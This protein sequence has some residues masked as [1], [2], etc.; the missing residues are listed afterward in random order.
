MKKFFVAVFATM[1][2]FAGLITG[3][4]YAEGNIA[5]VDGVEYA[6]FDEAVTAAAGTKTII[7]LADYVG[8][9]QMTPDQTLIVDKT[10]GKFNAP[11][12]T[13]ENIVKST[14]SGK[15]YTYTTAPASVE[16]T[17]ADGTIS[18]SDRIGTVAKGNSYR[19][20]ADLEVG[21]TTFGG[22][23]TKDLGTITFD[24]GGHTLTNTNTDASLGA[25][26]FH[27]KVEKAELIIK[28]GKI[29]VPNEC[30]SVFTVKAGQ[31]ITLESDLEVEAKGDIIA[32]FGEGATV[33]TSAALSTTGT[34]GIVGNGSPEN[35]GTII[36]ITGG[37][38]KS[39]EYA[40]YHPQ[41]G[42]I[43]IT[44]GELEATS[45]AVEIRAGELN[46][47]GGKFTATSESQNIRKNP[48]GPTTT[49]AALA[50][51]QHTTKLPLSV[52]ISGGE[53]IGYN[54][55]YEDNI[56]EN[57]AE[58]IAKVTASITGGSFS[59]TSSTRTPIESYDLARFISGGSYSLDSS[60]YYLVE[61]YVYKET[62]SGYVVERLAEVDGLDALR[63]NLPYDDI[64]FILEPQSEL[65]DD[66]LEALNLSEYKET[67]LTS[68]LFAAYLV[69]IDDGSFSFIRE[70]GDTDITFL[71][72]VPEDIPALADGY[73]RQF[74]I[75]GFHENTEDDSWIVKE[76]PVVFTE[77]DGEQY[78][79]FATREFSSFSLGYNDTK[80]P[81][82][83]DSGKNS[84]FASVIPVKM[85]FQA[86][87]IDKQKSVVKNTTLFYSV[88]AKI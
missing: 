62:E 36:N 65:L 79:S 66:Q 46:I 52:N 19:L 72:K 2:T 80:L 15:V 84:P 33:N 57:P 13:G 45:A 86:C 8:T 71:M 77:I 82:A 17:K 56:E 7:L 64:M 35:F 21:R 10:S 31:T 85:S 23:L 28:N 81:K 14:N 4:V 40:V 5:K 18:Y 55:F 11:T 73:S 27:T 6:T 20:L 41:D 75:L 24:L 51:A 87:R 47:S 54:A 1:L 60:A 29:S 49:G 78:F 34:Y 43:T 26:I 9:Y 63:E 67:N 12:V 48:N 50:I 44:D 53:F 42:K 22:T 58:D 30:Y 74:T 59:S 68:A 32:V 61:G 39:G 25:F 69:A 76:L 83:P 3:K 16:I 88:Y 37:S 70:T 38:I